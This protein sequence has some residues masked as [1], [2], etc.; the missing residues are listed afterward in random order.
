MKAIRTN[1]AIWAPSAH[2]A[3]GKLKVP[4]ITWNAAVKKGKKLGE[5][6]R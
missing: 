1:N 2:E 5:S 3:K 6:S 4:T